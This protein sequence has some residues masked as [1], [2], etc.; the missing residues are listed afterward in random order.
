MSDNEVVI[1]EIE[2]STPRLDQL[3]RDRIRDRP[4]PER[5]WF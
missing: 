3:R 5:R 1:L 4:V 2:H